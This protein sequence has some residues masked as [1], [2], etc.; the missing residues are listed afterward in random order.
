MQ[1]R[2]TQ[3]QQSNALLGFSVYLDTLTRLLMQCYA[4]LSEDIVPEITCYLSGGTLKCTSSIN[5]FL[6]RPVIVS[7]FLWCKYCDRHGRR[8]SRGGTEFGL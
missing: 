8:I 1:L 7:S 2:H 6:I 3:N 4:S 5:I